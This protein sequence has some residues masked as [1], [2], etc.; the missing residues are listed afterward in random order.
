MPILTDEMK[1]FIVK[2]LARYDTP[3]QVVEAVKTSFGVEI[4]RQQVHAY[5][6]GCA[7]PPAQRWQDLHAATRQ[8]FLSDL[9]EIGIAQKAF[10][11][12]VLHRLA[13]HAEAHH[14]PDLT[15]ALLEQAAKEC[16]GIYDRP[17]A[18]ASSPTKPAAAAT[19]PLLRNG[20]AA[21]V[22][23]GT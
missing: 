16:G 22:S 21:S 17:K 12:R 10:R 2:G 18:A 15:A 6:P 1:T 8:A 23:P 13:Q 20:D 5:D 11:L 19:E 3:S 4:S 7:K 14:Y 9:A